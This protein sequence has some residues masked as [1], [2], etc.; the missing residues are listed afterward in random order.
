MVLV[1]NELTPTMS[2]D[3]VSYVTAMGRSQ[4]T[5]CPGTW[6]TNLHLT[7][8]DNLIFMTTKT[9][10]HGSGKNVVNDNEMPFT[11]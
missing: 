3:I 10:C 11:N 7:P 8:E 6:Q 4:N 1:V 5:K 2:T 9:L